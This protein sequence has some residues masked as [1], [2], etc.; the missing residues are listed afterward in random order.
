[1]LGW[2]KGQ[3]FPSGF[4]EWCDLVDQTSDPRFGKH[5]NFSQFENDRGNQG[6][7]QAVAEMFIHSVTDQGKHWAAV[8]I[9]PSRSQNSELRFEFP[10]ED[11]SKPIGIENTHILN[12][13][14]GGVFEK[15]ECVNLRARFCHLHGAQDK[16]RVRLENCVIGKLTIHAVSPAYASRS[17][18]ELQ[19]C[20]I[21]TLILP[22][23]SDLPLIPWTPS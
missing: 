4:D 5:D 3:H 6:D 10:K 22:P 20:W 13:G 21:G 23:K 12:L 19:G 1:M 16:Y 11:G 9:N 8:N 2:I 17:T 14:I 18:L 7:W 15:V